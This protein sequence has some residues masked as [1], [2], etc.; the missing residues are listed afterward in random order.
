MIIV[1]IYL[2]RLQVD[3]FYP[4]LL[5]NWEEEDGE[6][7]K[8]QGSLSSEEDTEQPGLLSKVLLFVGKDLFV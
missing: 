4:K 1:F 7:G 6:E 3:W 8:S 5:R 2:V